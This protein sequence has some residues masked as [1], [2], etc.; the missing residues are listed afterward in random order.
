MS[1][2]KGIIKPSRSNVPWALNMDSMRVMF[3]VR[4]RQRIRYVFAFSSDDR[5]VIFHH[6]LPD[7]PTSKIQLYKN[8]MLSHSDA[9]WIVGH[10]QI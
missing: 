1:H 3:V 7:N 4:S 2:I 5:I 10:G 6:P 9:T 8:G